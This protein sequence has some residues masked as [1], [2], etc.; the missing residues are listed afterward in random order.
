MILDICRAWGQPPSWWDALGLHDR[1][2]L[3]GYW[4][5]EH[6]HGKGKRRK[7]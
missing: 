1:A 6:G 7:G 5:A 3:M 4:M 2:D